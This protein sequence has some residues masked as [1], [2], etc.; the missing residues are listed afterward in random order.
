M[1]YFISDLPVWVALAITIV[2]T[3]TIFMMLL[4]AIIR[5]RKEDK[6]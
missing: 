6:K 4:T 3:A 1:D 2:S 5:E